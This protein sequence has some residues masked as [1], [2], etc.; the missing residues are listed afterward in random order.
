MKYSNW[1]KMEWTYFDCIKN[2]ANLKEGHSTSRMRTATD[3]C[4]TLTGAHQ[5]SKAVGLMNRENPLLKNPLL[6]R[7]VQSSLLSVSSTQHMWEL[8]AGNRTAV[9]PRHA[10]VHVWTKLLHCIKNLKSRLYAANKL[11]FL[12][13]V[14]HKS[15]CVKFSGLISKFKIL[16]KSY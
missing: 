15:F 16:E 14:A 7:S 4:F 5:R 8:L 9:L 6:P 2:I 12:S 1:W 13:E 3:S 10:Q 11:V